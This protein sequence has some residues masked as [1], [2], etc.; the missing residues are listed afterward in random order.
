MKAILRG[1][2]AGRIAR[3]TVAGTV[4]HALRI[5]LQ[6]LTTVVLAWSMG[7]SGLGLFIG[8]AALAT[9][10]ATFTGVGSGLVLLRDASTDA[11]RLRDLW[12]DA[13]GLHIVT[14]AGLTLMYALAAHALLDVRVG[15]VTITALA[16]SELLL[17]PLVHLCGFALQSQER[18]IKANLMVASMSGARLVAAMTVS[19]SVTAADVQAFATAHLAASL[20]A[21][22]LVLGYCINQLELSGAGM[23]VSMRTARN[24]VGFATAWFTGNTVVEIDKPLALRFAGSD[25]AGL[26]SVAYRLASALTLPVATLVS[27]IQPRL[28][29]AMSGVTGSVRPL[30]LRLVGVAI[31]YG[32]MASAALWLL[33][34]LL[35]VILGSDFADTANAARHLVLVPVAYAV[36]LAAN[37]I[38]TTSGH[39]RP[40]IVVETT[41]ILALALSFPLFVPEH[42]LAAIT[43]CVTIVEVL[44][45]ITCLTVASRIVLGATRQ[46]TPAPAE[47]P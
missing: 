28:F 2:L 35:P 4:V 29:R 21:C 19:L 8:I 25:V 38:L 39:N 6:V 10:L 33:A 27:A 47:P 14:G 3:N 37:A 34:E 46:H 45:S 1:A 32:I 24:G 43:T 26:Y 17:M 7:P 44:M 41:G 20:T 12:R 31:G 36:R 11:G 15:M 22:A 5:G 16:I 40:R 42:G 23:A 18:L 13:L 30:A 9:C